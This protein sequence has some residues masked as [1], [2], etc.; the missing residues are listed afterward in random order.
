MTLPKALHRFAHMIDDFEDQ[1][2]LQNGYW[3]HL[4]AGFFNAPSETH[5]IHKDTIKDCVSLLREVE[6]CSCPDCR[7]E[8]SR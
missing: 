1:R 2:G 5:I 8:L 6:V 7:E 4:K 3:V